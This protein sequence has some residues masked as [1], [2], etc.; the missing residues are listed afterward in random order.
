MCLLMISWGIS[1]YGIM[2]AWDKYS[3]MNFFLLSVSPL[4]S[5]FPEYPRYSGQKWTI[6]LDGFWNVLFSEIL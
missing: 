4:P 5:H 6:I 3:F 1:C 2:S